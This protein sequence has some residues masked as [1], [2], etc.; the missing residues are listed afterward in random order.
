[1]RPATM[2]WLLI[3]I[4]ALPKKGTGAMICVYLI[5]MQVRSQS[6]CK[7]LWIFTHRLLVEDHQISELKGI[8]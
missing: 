3:S 4:T 5:A 1:M 2:A 7:T 6:R 8:A